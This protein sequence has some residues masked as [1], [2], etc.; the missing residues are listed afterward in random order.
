MRKKKRKAGGR[1]FTGRDDPRNG[2]Q[3]KAAAASVAARFPEKYEQRNT[4]PVLEVKL[5][6]EDVKRLMKE[7]EDA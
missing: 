5:G 1:V 6:P 4:E 7:V 2:D 3:K